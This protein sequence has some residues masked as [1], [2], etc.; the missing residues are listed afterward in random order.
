[1]S[2]PSSLS[3]ET[4]RLGL[5]VRVIGAAERQGSLAGEPRKIDDRWFVRVDFD[6][7]ARRNTPVDHLEL[8]PNH[9]DALSEIEA[10]RFHGP[11]SLRRNLLH[12]KL[13]GRLSEVLYSMDTSDT[14]FLAYQF[15]PILKLLESPTNSLLIADEVGLGKT[16]EA[17][18]IWTELKAREGARTLLVVCPPHLVTK[19]R[20]ELKRRF[21]VDAH[22]VGA[23]DLV[24][25][26]DEA[27][28]NQSS[29]FALVATYHGLRPP[30]DWEED[31]TR[32]AAQLARK[33]HA[34][35]D[36]EQP[37]LDLLVMEEAAI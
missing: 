21:G 25:Q 17:G 12:E 31:A 23:T 24:Q 8:L 10:G 19:W 16:I 6:D 2:L 15:K 28:R 32:P 35:G 3:S 11:E 5:R 4:C 1:M 34:W 33:L 20:N 9:L 37:F 27:R 22:P 36:G 30:D 7:G 18:L 26:L 13:H 29:G 14:H